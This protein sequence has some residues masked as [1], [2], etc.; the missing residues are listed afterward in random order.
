VA[1]LS[2]VFDLLARDRASSEVGKVGKSFDDAGDSSSKFADRVSGIFTKTAALAAGAGLAIGAAFSSALDQ[3]GQQT[4]LTARLGLDP[5]EA[6]AA[7]KMAGDLYAHNYGDSLEQVND[8]IANVR[9]NIDADLSDDA[10]QGITQGVLNLSSTFDVDLAGSTKAIAQLLNTG[11]AGS[12]QEALDIVTSGFQNGA[13]ASGDFLDTLNEYAGQFQ[14]L[15]L[16]GEAATSLIEQGLAAGARSGDLV[17]DALK[18]FSIRA[19]DGSQTTQ[20]GF[21]AVGLSASDM[22]ARIGAGGSSASAALADTMNALRNIQD[23]VARS[24]AAVELFGTQAEDLGSALYAL[25]PAAAM[26]GKGMND[27]SG[28]ADALNTTLSGGVG[29]TIETIKRQA[30]LFASEGLGAIINGFTQGSSDA[31]G[32]QGALQNGAAALKNELWPIV[33]DVGNFI[34]DTLIPALSDAGTWIQNNTGWLGPLAAAIGAV[35]LALQAYQAYQFLVTKATALWTAAQAIFNTVM[36]ANPLGIL[37]VVLAALAAAFAWAWTHSETFRNV[38]TGALQ[39]VGNIVSTVVGAI[40]GFFTVTLP[41]AI[42]SVINWF[43]GLP[44][45]IWSALGSL[46]STIASAFTGAIRSAVS[47]LGSA[48]SGIWDFFSSI[49]G[50]ILSVLGNLGKT[51]WNAG[52]DLIQGLLDGAGQLLKNIGKFF[53]NL[54]PGWIRGPFESVLGISSPSKVFA[55]YGRNIGQGLIAGLGEMRP[56]VESAVATLGDQTATASLALTSPGYTPPSTYDLD[57]TAARGGTT[58]TTYVSGVASPEQVAAEVDRAQRTTE[59]L[60]GV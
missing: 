6:A 39:W 2:L 44:G 20:Q 9:N 25:N 35:Y 42:G 33:Q 43:M 56:L 57:A 14:K 47:A 17:A 53:L 23:P 21:A 30:G 13:D 24:Q 41:G 36:A 18:E 32:W 3:A 40:V 59:F 34:K 1:D 38:V 37:L 15:G 52:K 5:G 29:P 54:L 28:A 26:S 45:R 8:A 11:L 19:V 60:A 49:P 50:R 16:T 7:G 31:G 22:A 48:A 51:L 46:A 12:A 58:H 55:E 4:H 10:F 27:M